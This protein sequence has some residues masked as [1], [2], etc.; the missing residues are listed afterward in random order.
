[1]KS[2]QQIGETCE[3]STC[4]F[5]PHVQHSWLEN[6]PFHQYK[7]QKSK[8]VAVML[9]PM[10]L[11]YFSLSAIVIVF[12]RCTESCLSWAMLIEDMVDGSL[13]GMVGSVNVC[14][15]FLNAALFWSSPLKLVA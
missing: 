12:E 7:T 3:A 6:T 1:M 14:L 8:L 11:E 2:F 9:T 4:L 10:D 15:L 5:R 13:S